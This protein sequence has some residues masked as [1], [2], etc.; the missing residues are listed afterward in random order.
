MC[1]D[2]NPNIFKLEFLANM[3]TLGLWTLVKHPLIFGVGFK[4]NVRIIDFSRGKKVANHANIFTM[5]NFR[6]KRSFSSVKRLFANGICSTFYNKWNTCRH[7][8]YLYK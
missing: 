4:L 5:Q 6:V 1:K 2:G 3:E 7:I 8:N